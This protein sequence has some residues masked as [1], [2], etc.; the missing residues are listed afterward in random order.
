MDDDA[1]GPERQSP[2][3]RNR[4]PAIYQRRI[5]QVL[6]DEDRQWISVGHPAHRQELHLFVGHRAELAESTYF[7]GVQQP[8]TR[9][10]QPSL[11]P[12]LRRWWLSWFQREDQRFHL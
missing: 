9:E 10:I 8:E 6:L 4:E 2:H 1:L 11:C 3:G 12:A 5:V 7:Q